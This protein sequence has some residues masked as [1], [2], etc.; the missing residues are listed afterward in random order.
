MLLTYSLTWVNEASELFHYC[1]TTV[2]SIN[3]FQSTSSGIED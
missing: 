2:S 3:N 1:I